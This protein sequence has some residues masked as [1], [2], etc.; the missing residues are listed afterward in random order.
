M[1]PRREYSLIVKGA[2]ADRVVREVLAVV[3]E[4][5]LWNDRHDLRRERI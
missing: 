2:S 5:F 3:V 1:V 4:P